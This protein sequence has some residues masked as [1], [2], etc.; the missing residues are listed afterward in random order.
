MKFNLYN[1]PSQDR[2]NAIVTGANSGVGLETTI[3]LVVVVCR[4]QPREEN[5]SRERKELRS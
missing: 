4:G 5:R 2:K 1:I 3:G